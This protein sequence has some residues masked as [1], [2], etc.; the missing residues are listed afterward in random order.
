MSPDPEEELRALE[1]AWMEAWIAKDRAACERMLADDFVLTSGRGVLM[2]KSEWLDAIGI[3]VGESFEW[4][5][6]R[7]RPFGD[8]AIVHCRTRQ[9]ASVAGQDWSGRFLITDVWIRR[10]DRWQVAS[11]H[12]T[13]PLP[14]ATKTV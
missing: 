4:E 1:R 3:F 10:N 11:R 6:V 13:G 12:G 14:D 7:V 9:R 2:T 5:D 8:V